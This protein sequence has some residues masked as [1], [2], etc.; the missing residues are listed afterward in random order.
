MQSMVKMKPA[1]SP[2]TPTRQPAEARCRAEA[3][4]VQEVQASRRGRLGA[5]A[6]ER[7]RLCGPVFFR[8]LPYLL[9]SGP[10]DGRPRS[11]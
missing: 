9:S 11:V 1:D 8:T 4:R 5:A 2:R 10:Q 7:V 6:V 3:H